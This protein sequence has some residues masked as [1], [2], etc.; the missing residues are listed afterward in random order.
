M[1]ISNKSDNW[2]AELKYY[3]SPTDLRLL[4]S[5]TSLDYQNI[6]REM[7]KQGQSIDIFVLQSEI[8]HNLATLGLICTENHG[9]AV[10]TYPVWNFNGQDKPSLDLFYSEYWKSLTR[11]Y[12]FVT[13]FFA[14]CSSGWTLSPMLQGRTFA[15]NLYDHTQL[16]VLGVANE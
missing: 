10:F 16:P 13:G 1:T 4:Y 7:G 9:S 14:T 8:S 15:T 6:G 11:K 12:Y 5:H 3:S 2:G